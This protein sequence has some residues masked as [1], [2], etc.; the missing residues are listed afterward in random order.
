M[1]MPAKK[2]VEA[3]L[4]A[5][6]AL[7]ELERRLGCIDDAGLT[8]ILRAIGPVNDP[9]I[10]IGGRD[11][12]LMASNDYLG[13]NRHP[14]LAEAALEA[15]LTSG[16]GSGASRLISGTLDAH[17]E[18]ESDI[19][20]FKHAEAALFMSTGY[21]TNLSVITGLAG[22]GDLIVSDELNHASIIDACRLS[23]AEV[24]VYP[25]CKHS[26]AYD[27]LAESEAR[28]KLLVTDGVFSMD[29]DIAPLPA[30][31][32]AAQKAGALLVVDDAH[33][34]GIWGATGRGT[35]E[36]FSITPPPDLVM[37]GTFSKALGGQGGFCASSRMVIDTL[38]NRARPFLYSTAPP[39]SQLQAARAALKLMDEEPELRQRLHALCARLR[40]GIADLGLSLVS[41][42][43]PIVP[44]LVGEARRTLALAKAL[45]ER[46]VYVPAIRPPTVPEGTCRLRFT[47]TAAHTPED[48]DQAVSAL[49]SAI[50]ETGL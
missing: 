18:L 28:L 16:T 11:C 36:H 33:G 6:S 48:I 17:E 30:L 47:V 22:P 8:R 13:L 50:E 39:P 42:E 10:T 35:V 12:L 27:R 43:G 14:R 32:S 19:A 3:E 2:Q 41:S 38:I 44:V 23:R 9:H 4:A 49:A 40:N 24:K 5:N 1:A 15:A 34:T 31:L 26:A 45:L 7:S 37:V 20:R 29:G 46:G 25:H 21:M